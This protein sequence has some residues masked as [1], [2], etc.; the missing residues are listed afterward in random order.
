MSEETIFEMRERL[1]K[2]ISS[3]P[4]GHRATTAW[5]IN[6]KGQISKI[7]INEKVFSFSKESIDLLDEAESIFPVSMG[8]VH[9]TTFE[10]PSRSAR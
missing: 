1:R 3:L 9:S 2:I 8:I 6:R 4:S 7:I 10:F 5:V